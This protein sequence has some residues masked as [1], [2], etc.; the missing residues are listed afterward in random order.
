MKHNGQERAQEEQR[1]GYSNI[2][3][4]DVPMAMPNKLISGLLITLLIKDMTQNYQ[5]LHIEEFGDSIP[6]C[7]VLNVLV[8]S[9]WVT[10]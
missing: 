2:L 5:G 9:V 1:D 4:H 10:N 3:V 6:I 7:Y 8:V